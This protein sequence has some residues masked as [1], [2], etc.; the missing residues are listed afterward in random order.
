MEKDE[1]GSNPI[2]YQR[3]KMPDNRSY[4]RMA[5]GLKRPGTLAIKGNRYG[6]L[7]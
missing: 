5:Q 6:P 1:T 3:D 2:R 4:S 7:T